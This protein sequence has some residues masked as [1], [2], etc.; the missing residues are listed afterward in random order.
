[1]KNI[2]L[3][4]WLAVLLFAT[5]ANGQTQT[6]EVFYYP[7]LPKVELSDAKTNLER[8]LKLAYF[9]NNE[10]NLWNTPE[11]VSVY[12]NRFELTFKKPN[13]PI[14]FYFHELQ[15]YKL[16]VIR[17]H[18]TDDSWDFELRLGKLI[19]SVSKDQ[20]NGWELPDYLY[21]F[22]QQLY[23]EPYSSRLVLFEPMAAQYR[24][25][26]VKPS[27][28]EGQRK[29][30][31][32]ANLLNQQKDYLKAIELYNKAV[33]LD[34]TSYPAAYS[35]LALLSAQIHDLQAAIY[36]MKKYLMLEPD[37]PDARSCQD[38]IYEWEL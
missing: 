6:E 32:Q 18:R 9:P 7:K 22:Q 19:I 17:I 4:T 2:R 20:K 23:P 3:M 12:D 28:S 35:N 31:V 16:K 10:H 37:A 26:K 24:A 15:N 29:Y 27:V 11:K 5:I 14:V 30:I 38:K 33:E 21:F 34:P 13:N 25:L 1:M 8:V 36:Y